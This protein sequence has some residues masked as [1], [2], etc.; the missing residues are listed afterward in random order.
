MQKDI[1]TPA[2]PFLSCVT[3]ALDAPLLTSPHLTGQRGDS[4]CKLHRAECLTWGRHT[5]RTSLPHCTQPRLSQRLS[6]SPRVLLAV[7][8]PLMSDSLWPHELQHAR[9][10]CL[11][12]SPEVFPSSCSLHRWCHPTMP[13]SDALVSFCPPSFLASGT[14]PM[15]HLRAS[16]DQNIGASALA[17]VF[18][19][20]IQGWSPLRLIDFLAVQGTSRSLF[21][22]HSPKA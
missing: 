13:S 6:P 12:P 9:L 21:Q 4:R 11:S 5:A 17:S 3:L 16:D 7:Q 20:N 22:H 18:P 1:F 10:P 2:L 15:S 8:V 14:F 19:V